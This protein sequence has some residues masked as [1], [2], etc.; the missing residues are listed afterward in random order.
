MKELSSATIGIDEGE[1]VLFSDYEDDG[2]MWSGS[3]PRE[4]RITIRFSRSFRAAPTV[5]ATLSMW[6]VDQSTN[7]RLDL[8][9]EDVT[10]TGFDAVFRTWEDTRVARARVR[11]IAIGP[12]TGEDDWDVT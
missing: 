10:E 9:T 2:E 4:R 1:D 7:A 6:D 11:W 12:V 3:G 5:F 8:A